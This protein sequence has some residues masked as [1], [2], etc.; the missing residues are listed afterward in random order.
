MFIVSLS[1]SVRSVRIK[2]AH[3][4]RK[5]TAVAAIVSREAITHAHY[6][7]IRCE[8][9]KD[10]VEL[11]LSVRGSALSLVLYTRL[12]LLEEIAA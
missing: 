4:Q 6:R 5:M 3:C 12:L 1:L 2:T 11:L 9:G 10:D 8:Y 7:Q